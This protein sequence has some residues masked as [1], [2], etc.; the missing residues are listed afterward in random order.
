VV[1]KASKHSSTLVLSAKLEADASEMGDGDDK[2]YLG[3]MG[4]QTRG[5]ERIVGTCAKLLHQQYFY[6]VGPQEARSWVIDIGST[7]AGT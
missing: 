3:E 7:A 1:I 5:I 6:T 2:E 4:L